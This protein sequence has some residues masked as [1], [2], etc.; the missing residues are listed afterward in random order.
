VHRVQP[1]GDIV[2]EVA[3]QASVD[4]AEGFL[5]EPMLKQSWEAS[6]AGRA[7]LLDETETIT[8]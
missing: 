6:G 7:W 4:E 2:D 3:A 1:A 8:Y 5:D